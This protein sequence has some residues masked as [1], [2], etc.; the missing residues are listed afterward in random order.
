MTEASSW[1]LA[2]LPLGLQAYNSIFRDAKES[3][4]GKACLS[5]IG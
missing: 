1:I 4:K 2:E 5:G 3:E